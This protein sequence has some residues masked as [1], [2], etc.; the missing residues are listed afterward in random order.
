MFVVGVDKDVHLDGSVWADRYRFK[1]RTGV[2]G[3]AW[4]SPTRSDFKAAGKE[5]LEQ[6]SLRPEVAKHLVGGATIK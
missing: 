5:Q 2:Y 3:T 6:T 1:K 4:E